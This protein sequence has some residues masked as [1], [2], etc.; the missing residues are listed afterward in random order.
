MEE[1]V[2]VRVNGNRNVA[3]NLG[4]VVCVPIKSKNENNPTGVLFD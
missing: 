2:A 3:W 1:V 4:A